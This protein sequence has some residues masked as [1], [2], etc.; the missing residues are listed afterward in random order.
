MDCRVKPGNDEVESRP[1]AVVVDRQHLAAT[2]CPN[3]YWAPRLTHREALEGTLHSAVRAQIGLGSLLLLFNV[4]AAEAAEVHVLAPTTVRSVINDVEPE[5]EH[6]TGHKL[7]VAYDVAPVVKRQIEGG[8]AFDVAIVTRPLMDDL[9][10]QGRVTAETRSDIG[11]AGAG[12]AVQ[13]GANRPDISS[14]D[15]LSQAFVNAKSIAYAAE[16]TTGVYFLGLLD[17]LGIAAETRPKLKPMGGGAVL[18]PLV[19]GEADL[20]V[21]TMPLIV[22]EHRVQLVGAVPSNLQ[23][24]IVFTAG[25]GSAAK[26]VEAATAFIRALTAPPAVSALKAH[27]FDPVTP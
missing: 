10:K 21:A 1:S 11:R 25:V 12:L 14:A 19:A 26:D 7:V 20:A 8:A 23:N 24:Y 2:S 6:A 16:G 4:A 27:G 13:A 18:S 17:R 3:L 22:E 15:A 9:I 5:F